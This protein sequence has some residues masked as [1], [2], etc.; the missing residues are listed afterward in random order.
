MKSN[1]ELLYRRIGLHYS[2]EI[3]GVAF[4]SKTFEEMMMLV[5]ARLHECPGCGLRISRTE[6]PGLFPVQL[7]PELLQLLL[8]DPQQYIQ[9]HTIPDRVADLRSPDRI[10]KLAAP[11]KPPRGGLRAGHD[12][13]ADA[14]GDSLY[15]RMRAGKVEDPCTG[16][17]CEVAALG[18]LKGLQAMAVT[19]WLVIA[20]SDLL[21]ID[22]PRFYLPREWNDGGS[23]ITKERLQEMY[24]QFRK[25]RDKCQ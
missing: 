8:D 20:T 15:L 4:T 10:S 13:L 11:Y 24:D 14:F 25:D 21:K 2:G 18:C 23:W 9:R 7:E 3:D 16:R 19:G 6:R 17:W 22:A 1:V 12:T 5:H